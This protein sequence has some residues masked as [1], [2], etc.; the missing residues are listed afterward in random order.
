MSRGRLASTEDPTA[1][2][3]L[4][5]SAQKNK[6]IKMADRQQRVRG[7]QVSAVLRVK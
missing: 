1:K 5:D 2:S 4:R 6:A 7:K 3:G